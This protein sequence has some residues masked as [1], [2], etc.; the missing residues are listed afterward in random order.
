MK[1][2]GI[3]YGQKRTGIAVTDPDATMAFP[4]RTLLMHG[5]DVFFAELL[6]LAEEER[7]EAFVVGLP[8]RQDGSDSETTRQVR[9]MVERLQRRSPLPVHLVPEALSSWDAEARLRAAGK[10]GKDLRDRL[11]QAAAVAILETFI[12]GLGR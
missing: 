3:D 4:R 8:L 9:N 12:Q 11:D 7:A 1:Y 5:K 10:G 6:A 2:L